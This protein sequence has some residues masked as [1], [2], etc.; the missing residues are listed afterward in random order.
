MANMDQRLMLPKTRLL[1]FAVDDIS[2]DDADDVTLD[3]TGA[4]KGFFMGPAYTTMTDAEGVKHA[5]A[6][7]SAGFKKTGEGTL[8]V[9][10]KLYL[11]SECSPGNNGWGSRGLIG[12][13]GDIR[14]EEGTLHLDNADN[15][16]T[17][18]IEV[19]GGLLKFY[20]NYSWSNR[21]KAGLGSLLVDREIVISGTGVLNVGRNQFGEASAYEGNDVPDKA[22]VIARNG[23]RIQAGDT[24]NWGN[25]WLDGGTLDY[26]GDGEWPHGYGGFLGTVKFSGSTPYEFNTD[27]TKALNCQQFHVNNNSKS[28]FDVSDITGDA[29]PDVTFIVPLARNGHQLDN[30]WTRAQNV[31][32]R[33]TGTGTMRCEFYT[34]QLGAGGME[35]LD[36]TV[37]V[38]EGTL[39]IVSGLNSTTMAVSA[40]AFVSGTGT[41]KGLTLA[42]GAGFV[43][44][45]GQAKHLSVSGAATIAGAGIVDILAEDVDEDD[46]LKVAV[47]DFN[48]TVSGT[49]NLSAWK[50]LLNGEEIDGKVYLSGKTLM[51]KRNC[52]LTL[53]FR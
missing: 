20:G 37:S 24:G 11:T 8:H 27:G 52:G 39:E 15:S 31:G 10:Q 14:V 47:V 48:G 32:F 45:P 3:G 41:I 50:V 51:V 7:Y 36:G 5:I 29:R 23:G 4:D 6:S 21:A 19:A 43:V 42:D 18:R 16:I 49:E 17:G 53:I 46:V 9:K 35:S 40:N 26:S 25:L 34:A 30:V 13:D 44:K 22:W 38:E 1:E 2:G 28:T 12:I 33:K